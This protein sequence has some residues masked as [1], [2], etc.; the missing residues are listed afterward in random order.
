MRTVSPKTSAEIRSEHQGFVLKPVDLLTIC[1]TATSLPRGHCGRGSFFQLGFNSQVHH[2]CAKSIAHTTP[3]MIAMLMSILLWVPQY[4][5]RTTVNRIDNR[6]HLCMYVSCTLEMCSQWRTRQ[7]HKSIAITL[8][9]AVVVFPN[10]HNTLENARVIE[11]H[12]CPL[13]VK[14]WEFSEL[15]STI[16]RSRL[17]IASQIQSTT[18]H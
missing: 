11:R 18:N 6:E 10:N 2:T 12:L 14:H 8:R 15:C 17:T 9:Y 5:S 1:A 7:L 13:R 3:K 16:T 4:A